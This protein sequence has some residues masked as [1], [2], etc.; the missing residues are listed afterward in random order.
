MAKEYFTSSG[1]A[2]NARLTLPHSRM[3][4]RRNI[5][6]AIAPMNPVSAAALK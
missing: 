3:A 5:T 6:N 2:C 1:W 4:E